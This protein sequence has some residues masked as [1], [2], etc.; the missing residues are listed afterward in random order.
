MAIA[1]QGQIRALEN[2]I[3]QLK[4]ENRRLTQEYDDCTKVNG[5][6]NNLLGMHG[7]QQKRN[8]TL[9]VHS[10]IGASR[11]AN[12]YVNA[13]LSQLKEGSGGPVTSGLVEAIDQIH[14]RQKKTKNQIDQNEMKIRKYQQ[15]IDRLKAAAAT[16]I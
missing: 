2:S 3:S 8:E 10:G 11:C 13:L 6:I 1:E 5:K 7:S 14:S 4:R 15:Q 16:G 12:S 9:I